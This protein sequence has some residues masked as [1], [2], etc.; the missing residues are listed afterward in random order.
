MDM[1]PAMPTE[2]ASATL[3]QVSARFH[4]LIQEGEDDAAFRL[5]DTHVGPTLARILRRAMPNEAEDLY[6]MTLEKIF[7][8]RARYEVQDGATLLSWAAQIARGLVA[9][10]R[11]KHQRRGERRLDTPFAAQIR[12]SSNRHFERL[13]IGQDAVEQVFAVFSDDDRLLLSMYFEDCT[14]AEIGA[15]LGLSAGQA[16][17]QRLAAAGRVRAIHA[18]LSQEPK[19]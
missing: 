1:S 3:H 8:H 19:R 6:A 4:A 7:I 11:R 14:D 16:R 13:V 18:R 10:L 5:F 9:N 2:H 12:E 15:A 17:K